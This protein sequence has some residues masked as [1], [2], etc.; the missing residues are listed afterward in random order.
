M[1]KASLLLLSCALLVPV[2]S[3]QDYPKLRPGLWE[4]KMSSDRSGDNARSITMCM[5]E[6]LQSEMYQMGAGAAKG[7]CSKH[8]FKRGVGE[9]VCTVNGST[10]HSKFTMT[11]NGDL[12]YR[13]EVQTT[14]DPPAAGHSSMHSTVEARYTGPCKTGQRPGDTTLPNGQTINMREM[15]KG[16]TGNRP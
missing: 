12:G 6:S 10:M 16:G 8:D 15:L 3:A 11:V 5:D 9:S 1:L 14:F 4:L 13:T 7:M 2:A